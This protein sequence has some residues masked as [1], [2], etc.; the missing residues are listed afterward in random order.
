MRYTVCN[1]MC[2]IV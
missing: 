2:N 1:I